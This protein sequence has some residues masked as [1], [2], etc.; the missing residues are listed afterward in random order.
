MSSWQQ[1]LKNYCAEH[2][3]SYKEAMTRARA[4]YKPSNVEGGKITMKGL[5]KTANKVSKAVKKGAKKGSKL[6]QDADKYVSLYDENL[7]AD[8]RDLNKGVQSVEKFADRSIQQTGGKIKLE[9]VVRKAKNTG[10]RA[11]KVAK[12]VAKNVEQYGLPIA[13]MVAPEVVLPLETG[14]NAYK[15]MNAVTGGRQN[16]YLGGS[17]RVPE[18]NG[19]CHSCKS[20]GALVTNSSLMSATHPSFHPV[21]QKPYKELIHTN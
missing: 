9:N 2:G 20:G 19:G 10:M 3:C 11:K 4:T 14:L 6:L 5:T 12:K 7:A 1:H 17:F 8:L 13:E 16:P 21:K 18:R 15:S